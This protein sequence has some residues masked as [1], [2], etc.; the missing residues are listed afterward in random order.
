MSVAP[1]NFRYLFE[2]D[3]TLYVIFSVYNYDCFLEQEE[4]FLIRVLRSREET[5]YFFEQDLPTRD[6]Y[7]SIVYIYK[8]DK[9]GEIEEICLDII[10]EDNGEDD[11]DLE[12]E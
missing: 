6:L 11:I 3:V 2:P 10:E 9:L 4:E 5:V 1:L 8:E 7:S 12:V